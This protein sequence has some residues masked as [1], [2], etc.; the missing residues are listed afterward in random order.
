MILCRVSGSVSVSALSDKS[1]KAGREILLISSPSFSNTE[2]CLPG[3]SFPVTETEDTHWHIRHTVSH[4]DP[5]L[6]ISTTQDHTSPHNP[7]R[8]RSVLYR[9]TTHQSHLSS[10]VLKCYISLSVLN[11]YFL[12]F[13]KERTLIISIWTSWPGSCHHVNKLVL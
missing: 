4:T 13:N 5:W 7:P 3:Q 6:S 1:S 2:E 10:S 8:A 11:I 12:D 9:S